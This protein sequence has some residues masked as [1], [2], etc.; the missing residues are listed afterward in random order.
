MLTA[1]GALLASSVV[2]SRASARF[3]VPVALLFLFVGVAAGTEGLGHIA[4]DDYHF[5]FRVG[6]AALVLILFD[7]GLNTPVGAAPAALPPSIVLATLGV[8]ATTG[9]VSAAAHALG[10]AWTKALLLG[11]IVSSTDAAAVFS[12]LKATGTR[13]RQRVGHTLELESGFNDPMAVILTTSLTAA[14]IGGGH[15]AALPLAG[16]IALQL[17]VG[18]AVGFAAGIAA[19]LGI[20]PILLPP[21]GP[22]SPFPLSLCCL[23]LWLAA[24]LSRSGILAGHLIG[25]TP[26]G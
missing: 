14:L 6:T 9:L 18:A 11:A 1:F 24:L 10:I 19:H 17:A 26:C 12:V 7:R 8:L 3:G 16:E 5:A 2:L 13:L 21:P 25:T 15:L 23:S 4:F 22:Y 20:L